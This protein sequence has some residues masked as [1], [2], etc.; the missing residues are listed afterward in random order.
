MGVTSSTE[1]GSA[2][3]RVHWILSEPANVEQAFNEVW[4]RCEHSGASSL[5]TKS[6][7]L[8]EI[9]DVIGNEGCALIDVQGAD[10]L[11]PAKRQQ[12]R[13]AQQL[14]RA[15]EILPE[16]MTRK[17]AFNLFRNILLTV[18]SAMMIKHGHIEAVTLAGA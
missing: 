1:T 18:Q 6:S 14:R 8:A 7:V 17:E 5:V 2:E 10:E 9:L 3:R 13:A 11:D 4:E 15:V 12:T 16:S